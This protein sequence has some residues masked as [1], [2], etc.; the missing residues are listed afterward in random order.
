MAIDEKHS[1]SALP[2]AEEANGEN[3]IRRD[4]PARETN[5]PAPEFID[6]EELDNLVRRYM[7]KYRYVLEE[8]AKR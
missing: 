8:L 5:D 3:D 7:E 1:R 4:T 6:G 2:A